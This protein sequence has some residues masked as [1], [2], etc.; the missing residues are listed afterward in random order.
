RLTAREHGSLSGCQLPTVNRQLALLSHLAP[1]LPNV[2]EQPA[3]ELE[4]MDRGRADAR[5]VGI[6][7]ALA[8]GT[9][10]VV[11]DADRGQIEHGLS[12]PGVL[13]I[14]Q[15]QRI[16]V[17]HIQMMDIVVAQAGDGMLT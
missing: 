12:D 9:I 15:S 8:L 14:D 3:G 4:S 6:Q 7:E 17:D 1:Q 16:A 11:I 5:A 2:V 10:V 13:P